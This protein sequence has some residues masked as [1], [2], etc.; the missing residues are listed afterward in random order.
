[1]N[2]HD[3]IR[4]QFRIIPYE[5]D[6]VAG[7]CFEPFA[8]LPLASIPWDALKREP[9]PRHRLEKS[10]H[11]RK[12]LSFEWTIEGLEGGPRTTRLY[13][14]RA[15]V[16][17]TRRLL[18]TPFRPSKAQEE[19][20]L[21]HAMLEAGIP[22]PLPVVYAERRRLGASSENFLVTLELEGA[23]SF[24]DW[25]KE[26]R[27]KA[28]REQALRA[29]ARFVRAGHEK[30]F[31]HDD[32]ATDH[33]FVEARAGGPPRM[34]F[35]DVDNGRL[36]SPPSER[37]RVKNAFQL[38]RSMPPGGLTREEKSAFLQEFFL[39]D[40]SD[41]E[42]EKHLQRI[43]RW[44]EWKTRRKRLIKAFRGGAGT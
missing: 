37:L 20:R 33:V 11:T 1:M 36:E 3:E 21:G 31:H 22:T 24:Y 25:F 27:A 26:L 7:L 5:A 43:E 41:A 10:S 16:R 39:R 38:F 14:K 42:F 12:V 44:R 17:R 15:R 13:A 34:F 2:L 6:G 4:R 32:C 30:G 9:D 8:A 18:L 28:E 29:L 23:K 19:W 35:I 40:L